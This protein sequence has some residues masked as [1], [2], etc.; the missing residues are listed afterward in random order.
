MDMHTLHI[1]HATLLGLYTL[2]TVVNSRLHRG[3]RGV[4]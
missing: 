3:T 2:L 4:N 1:E